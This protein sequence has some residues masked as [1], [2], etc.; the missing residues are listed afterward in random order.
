MTK[1]R[2]MDDLVKR[3]RKVQWSVNGEPCA[4]GNVDETVCAEAAARIAELEA[5]ARTRGAILDEVVP[6]LQA[7]I[8]ELE[9]ER[10]D[11]LARLEAREVSAQETND[12]IR[13]HAEHLR[14]L[15]E[16]IDALQAEYDKSMDEFV[17][18]TERG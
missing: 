12:T 15:K 9:A 17:E 11:L 8:K 6:A 3:L 5:D 13:D 7:R 18:R 2:L 1:E 16:R 4:E 14:R 10:D